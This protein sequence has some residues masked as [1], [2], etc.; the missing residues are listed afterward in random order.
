MRWLNLFLTCQHLN[1]GKN[2]NFIYPG[3][4]LRIPHVEDHWCKTP[5]IAGFLDFGFDFD[6]ERFY[7][8]YGCKNVHFWLLTEHFFTPLVS[9]SERERNH[10]VFLVLSPVVMKCSIFWAITPYSPLNVKRIFEWT[11]RL[12]IQG[13]KVNQA[14]NQPQSRWQAEEE[15][16]FSNLLLL[17]LFKTASVI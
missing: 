5:R 2:F 7:F 8:L 14:R 6:W 16:P 15:E 10:A 17:L 12:H 11:W 4:C 1:L 13:R 3:R 9:R